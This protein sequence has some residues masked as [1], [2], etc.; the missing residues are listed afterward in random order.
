MAITK[1][2]T[3]CSWY[4]YYNYINNNGFRQRKKPF[5]Y[6]YSNTNTFT[7]F[8][9]TVNIFTIIINIYIN[10]N[11]YKCNRG[12]SIYVRVIDILEYRCGIFVKGIYR[13]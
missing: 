10:I 9:F 1:N 5:F 8:N 12:K 3:A 13:Y 2:T 7:I 4:I 6:D 11:I